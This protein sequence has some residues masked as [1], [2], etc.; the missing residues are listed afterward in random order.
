MLCD[1]V[2]LWTSS[3]ELVP[4]SRPLETQPNRTSN[5]RACMRGSAEA[6]HDGLVGA[7]KHVDSVC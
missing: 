2:L 1:I 4:M 6:N 3:M 5:F 7:S